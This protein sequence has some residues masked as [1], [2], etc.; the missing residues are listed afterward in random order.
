MVGIPIPQG[1]AKKINNAEIEKVE[2]VET[3]KNETVTDGSEEANKENS[4]NQIEDKSTVTPNSSSSDE[5]EK[6]KLVVIPVGDPKTEYEDLHNVTDTIRDELILKDEYQVL[7]K[8]ETELFFEINPNIFSN[9]S[10]KASLN[11]YIEEAQTFYD[12]FS[13]KEGIN[14][15][16]STIETYRQSESLHAQYFKLTD[17]YLV[18]G[19]IY[20]G[21]KNNRAALAAFSE[22]LRLNSDL[23]LDPLQYPPQTIEVFNEA[24]NAQPEKSSTSNKL[25]IQA[26]PENSRIFVNG[27]LQ[28]ENQVSIENLSEGEHFILVENDGYRSWGQKINL[29]QKNELKISLKEKKEQPLTNKGLTVASLRDVDELVR[30]SLPIGDKL[31]V[32]KV[33]LVSL[34]EIGY[35]HRITARMID[36]EYRASHK[37]QSVEVLDLPKDTRSAAIHIANDLNKLSD[38]DLAANPK[39]YAESDVIVIGK[40]RKRPL[41]KNPVIWAL[42]GLV[43]AGGATSAVLLT[44][45]K[46]TDSSVTIGGP[47][48]KF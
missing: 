41:Y 30:L 24:K 22:A 31:G 43:I 32:D 46:D 10:E 12:N 20:V 48:T 3:L 11:R 38:V 34:E 42:L 1:F 25:D 13:F 45:D 36:I 14:L 37:S 9:E 23:S 7:T 40:K 35:N 19:N 4:Q 5:K 21:D 44:R 17:A 33:V 18:L 39:K 2:S 26:S 8:D 29:P 27:K 15:L 28:G 16:E 6:A 47:L